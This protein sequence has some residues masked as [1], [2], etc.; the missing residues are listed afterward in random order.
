M[1]DPP[2]LIPQMLQTMLHE[3]SDIVI[4]EH[5]IRKGEGWVKRLTSKYF[6]RLA[7]NLS[8][9]P[10]SPS[11]TDYRLF[12]RRVVDAIIQLKEHNRYLKM[13]Y[14][15]VGFKTSTVSFEREARHAGRSKYSWGR[16]INAAMDAIVAFSFKPLRYMSFFSIIISLLLGVLAGVIF[17]RKLIYEDSSVEGWASMMFLMCLLFSVQFIFMALISEYVSRIL[18]ESKRRPLYYICEK[19]KKGK[20]A[21]I[22]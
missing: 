22:P 12:S 5:S 10:M 14:A 16:L 11:A 20:Q 7:S 6:Y 3:Q 17:I 8:D 9:F 18:T 2:Y 4:A 15:Y 19:I 13:L 1:Q 21:E